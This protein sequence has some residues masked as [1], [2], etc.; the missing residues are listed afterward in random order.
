MNTFFQKALYLVVTV[1]PD[2]GRSTRR[3]ICLLSLSL[4]ALSN[5]CGREITSLV[6]VELKPSTYEADWDGSA[7]SSG[8]YFY[9]IITEGFVETKKMVL[10][11]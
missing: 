11:K 6:N 9:K 7:Y 3:I 8:V 5:L 2:I 4:M 10:M 1:Y